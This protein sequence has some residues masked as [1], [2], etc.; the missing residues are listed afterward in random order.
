[1]AEYTDFKF[2]FKFQYDMDTFNKV[3]RPNPLSVASRL[4]D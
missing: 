3:Y 4:Y 2:S 1:M